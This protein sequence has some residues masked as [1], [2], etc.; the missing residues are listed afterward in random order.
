[1]NREPEPLVVEVSPARPAAVRQ[2]QRAQGVA[3]VSVRADGRETRL[4]RLYQ[5]GC[6]KIRLPRDAEATGLE[7]VLINT[8]G[9]LTG[10]DRLAWR[11]DAE[12]GPPLTLTTQACERI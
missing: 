12:A 4:E 2:L 8:A 3:R 7:A 9:G 1:M 5:E 11:A 10:G 6:A